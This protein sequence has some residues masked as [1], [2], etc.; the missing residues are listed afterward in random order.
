MIMIATGVGIAVYL[1]QKR[2]QHDIGGEEW[3]LWTWLS[4]IVNEEAITHNPAY[5]EGTIHYLDINFMHAL[6][7]L[8]S[9]QIWERKTESSQFRE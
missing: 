6:L 5:E 7:P 1:K 3:W 9:T 8:H 4:C 2:S